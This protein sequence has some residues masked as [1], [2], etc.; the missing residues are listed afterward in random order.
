[1]SPKKT[2]PD[3]LLD[4]LRERFEANPDRHPGI[5]WADVLQRLE[6]APDALR[7]LAEMERTGGEPD[8]IARDAKTGAVTFCDCAAQ[9]PKGRRSIC[10]DGKARKARK[11]HPPKSS[12]REMADA[13]GAALLTAEQ[14]HAL[15]ALG[16]FD[17][18]TSSWLETPDAIRAQGGAIFGD[19]RYGAVFIYHNGADSY[20][21][22]RGFR[23]LLRV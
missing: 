14:Y 15:Q 16:D 19:K 6:A 7:T 18:T 10:Y 1:M 4:T 22:A 2:T 20:Y 13:M 5:D 3:D 23:G 17:T 12:A 8:V 21:A 11:K 9:S